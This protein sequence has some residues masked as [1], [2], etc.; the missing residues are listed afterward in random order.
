[1]ILLCIERGRKVSLDRLLEVGFEL[2]G[3]WGL[4]DDDSQKPE[5]GIVLKRGGSD[6]LWGTKNVL[7]AFCVDETVS[8]VGKT[9][10]SA[11]VR[12]RGYQRPHEKQQTNKKCQINIEDALQNGKA[13]SI[14]IFCPIGNL[15][16]GE[17]EINL[18]A[19]LEDAIIREIAPDWNGRQ[20][21]IISETRE[22]EAIDESMYF[23]EISSEGSASEVIGCFPVKLS[24]TYYNLGSINPGIDASKLLGEHGEPITVLLGDGGVNVS[25][26][27]NRKANVNGSVRIVGNNAQIARWFQDNFSLDS[28]VECQILGRNEIRLLLPK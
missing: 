24:S 9:T 22:R 14:Y 11:N 5:R 17:F 8:Y 21:K 27:I 15:K 10:N 28:N 13:V 1:M 7:Y 19:A 20:G 23:P 16:Y 25:S 3:S 6:Y 26:K 2:A 12:F 4:S 18:A